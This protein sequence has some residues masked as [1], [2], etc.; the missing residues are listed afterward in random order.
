M[1]ACYVCTVT[2]RVRQRVK[3][4][5]VT[6][7]REEAHAGREAVAQVHQAAG[8]TCGDMENRGAGPTYRLSA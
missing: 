1:Y 2:V 5:E 4:L 7:E 8:V 3:L 6:L